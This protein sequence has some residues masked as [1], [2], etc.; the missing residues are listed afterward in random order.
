[1]NRPIISEFRTSVLIFI[2]LTGLSSFTVLAQPVLFDFN[3]GPIHTSLPVSLTAGGI[4]AHFSSTGQ[5]FSIQDYFGNNFIPIGFSGLFICPNSIYASDLIIRFDQTIT[6]F[7]ILY[8]PEEYGCDT[9]ATMRVTG[10]MRGSY[11]GTNTKVAAVPGTWPV[12]TLSFNFP[13]GFDS[14][15]VHYDSHPASGCTDWGPIFAADDMR[16]TALPTGIAD[17]P[18]HLPTE[19]V[20]EDAYPTPFN[21]ATTIR[22][23]LP[24]RSQVSLR[25]F[26]AL[27]QIVATVVDATEEAG[28]K[29]A[30]W[31]GANFASGVYFYRLEA[32]SATD[33]DRAF[34]QTK[35]MVL[36][37]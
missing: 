14:V 25:V 28:Y 23:R 1:M 8:S 22:Y 34:A 20:L 27:G 17:R 30:S 2:L 26:D 6:D 15:V 4:T 24:V 32:I 18:R 9:S 13:K 35:T 3:N 29:S 21:P 37:K 12:D 11:V 31:N 33:R 16:V 36:V 10:Y 19:F 5:G 7:S